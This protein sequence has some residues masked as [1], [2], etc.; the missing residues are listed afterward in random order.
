MITQIFN[1]NRSMHFRTF[2]KQLYSQF[3]DKE[4]GSDD[5]L[6]LSAKKQ[7]LV[8]DGELSMLKLLYAVLSKHYQLTIKSSS[9]SAIQWL[10]SGNRPALIISELKLPFFDGP[11]FI[12]H[13][14]IS[15][16]HKYTPIIVLSDAQYLEKQVDKLPFRVDAFIAKPFNPSYLIFK[17]N[18]LLNE[19]QPT[20][21]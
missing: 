18:D 19:Y 7:V 11:A 17:I 21:A 16:I 9:L 5:I 12:R 15:G 4:D 20:M 3:T 10:E 6:K 13:L 2:W 8:V 14:K 1:L